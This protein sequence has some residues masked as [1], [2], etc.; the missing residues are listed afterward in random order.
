MKMINQKIN[1]QLY[2]V[3][4]AEG[5]TKNEIMQSDILLVDDSQ[6]EKRL[7]N[8]L[9]GNKTVAI[10][11]NSKVTDDYLLMGGVVEIIRSLPQTTISGTCV[12]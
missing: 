4:V 7:M 5:Y 10:L 12:C 9:L 1:C 6:T 2:A 8:F 11:E 3:K